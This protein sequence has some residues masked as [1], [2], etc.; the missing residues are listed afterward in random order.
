MAY[1]ISFIIPHWPL[2]TFK[3]EW[4]RPVSLIVLL[5]ERE[6]IFTHQPNVYLIRDVMCDNF[7]NT[8]LSFTI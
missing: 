4:S 1:Y 7:S 3:T 8:Y 5:F 2:A 6:L